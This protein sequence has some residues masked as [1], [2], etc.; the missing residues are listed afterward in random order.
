[1]INT[2]KT[3]IC[4][5]MMYADKPFAEKVRAAKRDGFDAIEFWKWSNKD[6][7]EVK[8]LLDETGLSFAIMNI[9]VQDETLSYDLSRGILNAGRADDLIKAIRESA[10]VYHVVGATALI[11][12]IGETRDDISKEEQY[13]NVY[14]CLAAAASVAEECDV[15]LIVE[16]LNDIDR[17]NYFMPYARPLF[18]ILERVNS[19]R[20]KMLYD[21][22]HQNMMGDFSLDD[23]HEFLHRIGHFHVADAPG[24]HQPGTG[25]V[26]YV[27]IL[28]DICS[29]SYDGY[30]GLEYRPTCPDYQTF[31]FLAEVTP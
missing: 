4:I 19:P 24:R 26:D 31:G 9:D 8:A 17:K 20:V 6:I 3:S 28:R 7:D 5:D 27:G 11:V 12:L 1:M 13:E 25:C 10:P 29:T 16:P 2:M 22:Y 18:E 30:I 21:I 15:N 14:R 23:V